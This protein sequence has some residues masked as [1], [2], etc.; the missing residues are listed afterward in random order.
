MRQLLLCFLL[1]TVAPAFAEEFVRFG[2]MQRQEFSPARNEVIKIPILLERKAEVRLTLFS[3]DDRAVRTLQV[4]SPLKKGAHEIVWDGKDDDGITVPDEA[5]LPVITASTE[6]ETVRVDPRTWSGGETIEDIKLKQN[7]LNSYSY[8]LNAPAR[9]S[10]RAGIGGGPL[11]NLLADWE[12]HGAGRNILYWDGY[13]KNKLVK[14]SDSGKQKLV[15]AAFKLPD[16]SIITSGNRELNYRDYFQQKGWQQK[17]VDLSRVPLQ[18]NQQPISRQYYIPYLMNKGP[19]VSI[20]LLGDLKQSDTGFPIID[21]QV[22]IQVSMDDDSKQFMQE[23]RYEIGFFVDHVFLSEEEQ[24]YVPLTWRW[25]PNHLDPGKHILT[26][27]V[28]GFRGQVGVSSLEFVV[29][30]K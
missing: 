15:T 22:D 3:V 27:N 23:S 30:E 26:V 1:V 12:P 29:P 21:G 20:E 19:A 11:L 14:L 16:H 25:K 24:G 9:V 28:N 10:I 6:S 4:E 17:T 5:W 8:K 2:E 18:R 7:D 13:D